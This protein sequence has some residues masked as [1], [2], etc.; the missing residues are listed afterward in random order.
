MQTQVRGQGDWQGS[1]WPKDSTGKLAVVGAWTHV[2]YAGL[3]SY[4]YSE[5][6]NFLLTT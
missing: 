4:K 6:N 5:Y 3:L 1:I 2:H